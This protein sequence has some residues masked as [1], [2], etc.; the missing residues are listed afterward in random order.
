MSTSPDG[1]F[2]FEMEIEIKAELALAESSRPGE[3]TNLPVSEWPFDPVDVGRR[4]RDG[5]LGFEYALC[6]L[7]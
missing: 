7:I 5:E 2:E 3:I 6:A 4:P 1:D